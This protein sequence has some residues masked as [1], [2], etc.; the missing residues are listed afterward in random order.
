MG[1]NGVSE[2]STGGAETVAYDH[3]DDGGDEE[4]TED[5]DDVVDENSPA[6]ALYLH[7]TT[8]VPAGPL[9]RPL[10]PLLL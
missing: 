7:S 2:N 1:N 4:I 8:D 9:H 3:D 5:N 6:E 10:L